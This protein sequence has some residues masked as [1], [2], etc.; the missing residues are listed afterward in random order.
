MK[1]LILTLTVSSLAWASLNAGEA[2]AAAASCSASSCCSASTAKSKST[3]A[4]KIV[5]KAKGGAKGGQL[6]RINS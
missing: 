4:A 5:Q 6:L 2:P 3:R 1:K